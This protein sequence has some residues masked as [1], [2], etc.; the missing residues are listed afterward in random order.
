MNPLSK[1]ETV[2]ITAVI[3]GVGL[4]LAGCTA[5]ITKNC[6]TKDVDIYKQ[7]LTDYQSGNVQNSY[8]L[9]SKVSFMSD[10]K[11]IAI[12][13]QAKCAEDIED[14]DAAVKQYQLLFNNYP[15]HKL[16]LRSKYNAARLLLT[17]RPE[18]AKKYFDEILEAAPFTDYGIAA[19]YFLGKMLLTSSQPLSADEKIAVRD[20]YRSYLQKSPSGRWVQNILNEIQTSQLPLETKDY[21][22]M[23][24]SYSLLGDAKNARQALFHVPAAKSWA[25]GAKVSYALGEE[26]KAKNLTEY[27]LSLHADEVNI[28]DLYNAVDLYIKHEKNEYT[29]LTKLYSYPA[30]AGKDYIL[31]LKCQN[32]P[33]SKQLECY[34]ELY[35]KF[36][37][38]VYAD[39]ALANIFLIQV[40][41]KDYTTAKINGRSYLNKYNNI[42]YAPAI[43]YWM[44][45]L[46]EKTNNRDEYV[47]F[48]RGVIARYPDNYYAY[49]AYLRL[50]DMHGSI[51]NNYINEKEVQYPYE[52]GKG[53]ELNLKLAEIGDYDILF[54]LNDD[55]FI[56]S[57]IY[58][59]KGDYSHSM[60]VARDAMEKIED[61]PDKYDLR[62]RLVYPIDYYDIIKK[63]SVEVGNNSPLI[64]AIVREESY[65]NPEANS[66]VGA[67]GLMQL[68]LAT[69]REIGAKHGVNIK[70]T[71]DLYNPD[72]NIKLGN[73]YYA[74]LKSML[75]GLDISSVAAYNGGIGSVNRWKKSL[76]YNDTDEFVEQIPYSETKDYVKKVFRSYWNYIRI[77]SG[78]E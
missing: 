75:N 74:E 67:G 11:P 73:Y 44:G 43:M 52:K 16:S 71:E 19:E 66:H 47:S 31:N 76:Y 68:M 58:Y 64:L 6:K 39:D 12:Y 65:F 22:L 33:S 57:W 25:I 26:Q 46:A 24:R 2:I 41:N 5:I 50:N 17:T 13:R 27:G 29:A 7:A 60:L 77:Y 70:T 35:N 56:K 1:K 48:Y 45:K 55:E 32:S 14:Y 62:W 51:I 8:Y 78:N 9:F 18:V 54:E 40:K 15:E 10:L 69:A 30:S 23:A 34:R 20:Y 63:Y 36:P 72:T 49:R 28:D 42:K 53:D 21:L 4:A 37:A 38:S 3:L 59:Q 61:K